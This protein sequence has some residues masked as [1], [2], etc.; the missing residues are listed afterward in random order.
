M[1]AE[2]S[3]SLRAQETL[4]PET[5]ILISGSGIAGLATACSLAA[6]GFFVTIFEKEEKVQTVGAGIQLSPNA[7]RCLQALGVAEGV[8]LRA[9]APESLQIRT[10][11]NPSILAQIAL[12]AQVTQRYG[13]PY[14]LV[15]R[16]DLY[17]VLLAKAREEPKI[18]VLFGAEVTGARSDKTGITVEFQTKDGLATRRGCALIGADGAHSNVRR[19]ILGLPP[20]PLTG[21]IAYRTV[22]SRTECPSIAGLPDLYKN[23]S[24]WLGPSCHV[25]HYPIQSQTALNLVVV[26]TEKWIHEK[27]FAQL[28]A[29]AFLP[30]LTG[31]PAPLLS[32]LLHT[33]TWWA[34]A[35]RMM[36]SGVIWTEERVAL[37]GDAAHTMLPS[38]AQGAAMA[39]EDALTLAHS[40]AVIPSVP[41]AFLHF[42]ENR[43]PR[44]ER[45][46][47]AAQSN[48]CLYH[49][50]SVFACLR[51]LFLRCASEERILSRY[52]WIY[53]WK[54]EDLATMV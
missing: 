5:P 46:A 34:T 45:M 19:H 39:L 12:G 29:D 54:P 36:D 52:D 30:H 17:S 47:H 51:N 22:V 3:A 13:A 9:V 18:E 14:W 44:V 33:K 16:P 41:Q 48:I 49:A 15:H 23:T 42:E 6:R 25:L 32:L 31:W 11:R 27:W 10:H 1:H 28:P 43:K 40:L 24:L 21:H 53:S 4:S 8:R 20:P 2:N 7:V 50:H 35:L 38:M 26:V 37:I